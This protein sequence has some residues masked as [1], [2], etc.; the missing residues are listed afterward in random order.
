M[1]STTSL[2]GAR[3]KKEGFFKQKENNTYFEM[4]RCHCPGIITY[5]GD[6]IQ[7]RSGNTDVTISSACDRFDETP[8][9]DGLWWLLEAQSFAAFQNDFSGP[10][11]PQS[12]TLPRGGGGLLPFI[13]TTAMELTAVTGSFRAT[14][15]GD[16]LAD[17]SL[18]FAVYSST[19][20]VT[21]NL[22]S[23][24]LDD[25]IASIL[26]ETANV[27]TNTS[28]IKSTPDPVKKAV[29]FPAGTKFF[30]LLG[31]LGNCVGS[32]TGSA[33]VIVNMRTFP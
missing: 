26:F 15:D 32:V 5:T 7:R 30:V 29:L 14:A 33:S 27:P 11:L 17:T 25:L 24:T 21:Y 12:F 19:D 28:L 4:P 16:N 31:L 2:R 20:G 1:V 23:G 10:F 3:K 18:V 6:T 8:P 9:T 22:I 13:A